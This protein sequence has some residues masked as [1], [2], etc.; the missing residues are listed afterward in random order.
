MRHARPD[1]HAGAQAFTERGD[2]WRRGGLRAAAKVPSNVGECKHTMKQLLITAGCLLGGVLTMMAQNPAP[3]MVPPV[4]G[5][6]EMVGAANNLEV[7]AGY[8]LLTQGGN[9]VDAGGRRGLA[10]A[11]P[12]LSRFGLGGEMP[13]LVKMAG[14]PVMAISGVGVAPRKATV[15]YYAN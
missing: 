12:E 9:A 11:V 5:T 3:T 10:A 8:R 7:E 13:L 14:K 6:H 1:S 4:R 2:G 15:E